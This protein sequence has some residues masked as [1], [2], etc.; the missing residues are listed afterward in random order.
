MDSD[1]SQHEATALPV[2][3][4]LPVWGRCIL[5]SVAIV[6]LNACAE[7]VTRTHLSPDKSLAQPPAPAPVMEQ[8]IPADPNQIGGSEMPR[9]SGVINDQG[10]VAPTVIAGDMTSCDQGPCGASE[11]YP[12][13]P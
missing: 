5:I 13:D 9:D 3:E 12:F 6:I 7:P 8:I 2:V 10:S 4:H 1:T 11:T